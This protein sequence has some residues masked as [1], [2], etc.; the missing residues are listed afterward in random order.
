MAGLIRE[1]LLLVYTPSRRVH[2]RVSR[3]KC[4]RLLA[5]GA[6]CGDNDRVHY[7]ARMDPTAP[8]S[9]DWLHLEHGR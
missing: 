8:M 1:R 5:S 6:L 9:S 4:R 2:F 7:Q 3:I